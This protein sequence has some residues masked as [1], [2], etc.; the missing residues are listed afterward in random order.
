MNDLQLIQ[1]KIYEIRG[2]RVMLDRDLAMLYGV[3]TKA[4]KRAVRRNIKRFPQDFMFEVTPQEQNNLRCQSGTP[5]L[6]DNQ[7]DTNL[8]SQIGTSNWGGNRYN[9]FAFTELG[10]AMLSSVLNSETAIDI[11]INI[12]RAFVE[13]R[14]LTQTAADNYNELRKEIN[15][16]KDYIEEIL[17]DQND[18]NEEHRAQLDAISIALAELQSAQKNRPK[19]R[20]IGFIQPKEDQEENK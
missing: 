4:L 2:L 10:V 5:S 1:Q 6:P 12:M 7:G 3:E 8:R 20:P 14:R 9:A 19:H 17:E 13:L 18:I 16:V 15:S 11:N